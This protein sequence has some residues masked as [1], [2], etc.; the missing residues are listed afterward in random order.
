MRSCSRAS[1][2]GP[3]SLSSPL[4]RPRRSPRRGSAGAS[5]S[6]RSS[7]RSRS[8][9]RSAASVTCSSGGRPAGLGDRQCPGPDTRLSLIHI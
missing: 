7:A 9:G 5:T 4:S 6:S 1:S 2:E 8:R 3:G